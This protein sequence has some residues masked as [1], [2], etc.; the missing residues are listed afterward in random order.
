MPASPP[1]L[2]SKILVE[3][4]LSGPYEVKLTGVKSSGVEIGE[5]SLFSLIPLPKSKSQIFTGEIYRK[6]KENNLLNVIVKGVKSVAL[7]IPMGQFSFCSTAQ[8][9]NKIKKN[10]TTKCY[11]TQHIRQKSG[12]K[13]SA[14]VFSSDVSCLLV[15][16]ER[17][18]LSLCSQRMFSGFR[19]R[20]AIPRTSRRHNE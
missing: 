9:K 16:R 7:S 14:Y 4:D 19:S 15:Y 1:H 13:C 6:E 5:L 17:L 2:P 12:Q 20:C 3:H 18:T 11:C 8:K 10:K